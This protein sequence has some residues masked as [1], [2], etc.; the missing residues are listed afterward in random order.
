MQRRAQDLALLL[1]LPVVPVVSGLQ[2]LSPETFVHPLAPCVGGHPVDERICASAALTKLMD[3][4]LLS[5]AILWWR[6]EAAL[7]ELGPDGTGAA[8]PCARAQR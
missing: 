5:R 7:V 2:S 3:V 8:A 6:G 4:L 1:A